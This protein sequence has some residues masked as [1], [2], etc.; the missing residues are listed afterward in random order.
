MKTLIT[1]DDVKPAGGYS[2]GWIVENCRFIYLAGH[3]PT[4]VTGQTVGVGEPERQMRQ[5]FEN[6][7]S[8]L[9]SAGATLNDIVKMTVFVTNADRDLETYR[10]VR[11]E[12]LTPPL[13]ASTLVEVSRLVRVEWVVEIEAVAAISPNSAWSR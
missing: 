1:S 11:S 2:L 4:D 12:F 7:R 10:R 3:V 8:S 13:P 9:A 6:L 5:V